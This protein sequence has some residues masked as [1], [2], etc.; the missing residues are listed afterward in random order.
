MAVWAVGDLHGMIGPLQEMETRLAWAA[1]RDRVILLG[2]LV[3]RG[4]SGL[5][6]LRWAYARRDWVTTLLG[7]HDVA[8]L[9]QHCGLLPVAAA[10]RPILAA[11][12]AGELI[13]WLRGR[14]LLVEEGDWLLVHA[15]ILPAWS[16]S[17]LR[18][19][20]AAVAAAFAGSNWRQALAAGW[21]NDQI[22]D[23]PGAAA[24]SQMQLAVNALCRLRWCN[25]DGSICLPYRQTAAND[26][27]A[28]YRLRQ[29][30]SAPVV[31]GHWS[32]HGLCLDRSLV[33]LD[34]GCVYR[35]VLAAWNLDE[36]RAFFVG[37]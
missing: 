18:E 33:M 27:I 3:G 36:R 23:D 6:V 1:G 37:S 32:E 24:A 28:W 19:H 7:N 11:A 15:G 29:P 26:R 20:A 17:R 2:D 5:A 21:G 8:L 4:R 31:C 10:N 16:R 22:A 34:G 14:P 9:M 12:D 35:G 30:D 13:A 25:R